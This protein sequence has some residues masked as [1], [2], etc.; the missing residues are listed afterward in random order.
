M[1]N[2]PTL[3]NVSDNAFFTAANPR[4]R[5][6]EDQIL[7][8]LFNAEVVELGAAG[9]EAEILVRVN[10]D[11]RYR[12]LGVQ[13]LGGWSADWELIVAALAE[14]VRGIR[15][16]DSLYDRNLQDPAAYPL[17]AEARLGKELFFSQ[18]LNCSACHGGRNF[19]TPPGKP[20]QVFRRN[21]FYTPRVSRVTE[22]YAADTGLALTTGRQQDIGLYRIPTLRNVTRTAPYM[23]DGGIGELEDVLRAYS[24]GGINREQIDPLLQGFVL[25]EEELRALVSFLDTLSEWRFGR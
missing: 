14:Y 13:H 16:D 5:R 22:K 1:R 11:E 2:A 7:L 10:D 4:L 19:N 15:S 25:S 21:G 20:E 24:R 18:R 3:V 8:P 9:H 6:L 23:H 17:S 12:K